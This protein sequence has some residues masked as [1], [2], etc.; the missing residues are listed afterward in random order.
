MNTEH[1][2]TPLIGIG[3][4]WFALFMSYIDVI[5][6]VLQVVGLVLGC[7]TSVAAFIYYR[8]HK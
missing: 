3:F 4:T 1:N 6:K 8:R 7:A 2:P 5:T